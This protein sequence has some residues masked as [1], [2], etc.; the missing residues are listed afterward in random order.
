MVEGQGDAPR[1]TTT[2][3]VP[4]AESPGSTKKAKSKMPKKSGASAQETAP[5]EVRPSSKKKRQRS[6]PPSSGASGTKYGFV[7]HPRGGSNG[8]GYA[9]QLTWIPDN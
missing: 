7:L 3:P 5:G 9:R 2:S 1:S 4:P 8:N 6:N